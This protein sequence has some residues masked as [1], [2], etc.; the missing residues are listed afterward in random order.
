MTQSAV[1]IGNFDGV[2]RGHQK[3]IQRVCEIARE[4]DWHP[5]VLTFE[6]HP[7]KI[8]APAKAPKLLTTPA[9]RARLMCGHGIEEV[10]VLPFD[11]EM[12]RLTPEQFVENVLVNSLHARAVVVGDNF[13]FGHRAA[14][15]VNALRQF[16]EKYGFSTEV[17]QPVALRNGIVSS[18]AVRALIAE[19]KVS[20]A[21]RMLGRPYLIEGDIVS[22]HGIGSKQTVPTL[23]LQTKAEVL[24]AR[25][26]YVTRTTDGHDAVRRW[27][28]ITNIGNRPTF[29]G[30]DLSIETFLLDP[31]TGDA[32]RQIRLEFLT[33]V[34]D[35]RKFENAEALKAQ[36]LRDVTHAQEYFR[37]TH[38]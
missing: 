10:V 14:G 31:L 4:N 28:S 23:N 35:E 8:V 26:V 9:Q 19:G 3:L 11:H 29:G 20:R 21:C 15:D 30:G 16:G 1:T 18:S 17:V 36:I 37:R 38:Q 25:G 33:R 2:H 27:R 12:A 13:R 7:A 32:P 34:R 5:L 6:P 22:G 24:P